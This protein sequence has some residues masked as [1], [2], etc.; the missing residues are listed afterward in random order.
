MRPEARARRGRGHRAP[1]ARS[2]RYSTYLLGVCDLAG[3]FLYPFSKGRHYVHL[4]NLSF[5]FAQLAE[6]DDV[7]RH[8]TRM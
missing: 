1:C 3:I 7:H 5:V 2:M 4:T 6:M 8:R